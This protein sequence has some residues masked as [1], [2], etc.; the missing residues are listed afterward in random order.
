MAELATLARPYANAAYDLAKQG[1]RVNA[2]SRALA[3]LVEAAATPEMQA[4]IGSRAIA[5]VQKAHAL[6]DLLAEMDAPAEVKRFVSVLAENRRLELLA[7]IA[8][9]FETKRAEDSKILDVTITSAVPIADEQLAVFETALGKR[10][11]RDIAVTV[12]T[13][14]S[15]LGGAFIRA[16]DTVVDGSVRGKLA[17]MAEA[18]TRV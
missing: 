16:G 3:L 17:K 2:W 18:L 10:F 14:S 7:D 15:L 1:D 9:L 6:N 12:E 8:A 5:H 4:L 13:D 11:E